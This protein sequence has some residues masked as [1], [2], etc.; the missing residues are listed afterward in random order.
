M[1]MIFD[2]ADEHKR[3]ELMAFNAIDFKQHNQPHE[4][5]TVNELAIKFR[6]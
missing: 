6:Q 5:G 3:A 1:Q 4:M 2:A